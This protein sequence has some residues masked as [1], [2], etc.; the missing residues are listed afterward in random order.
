MEDYDSLYE[1]IKHNKK[2]AF[3]IFCILII[4][5]LSI[6]LYIKCKEKP[7]I[8]YKTKKVITK[9]VKDDSSIY[10]VDIKGK[11][12]KPGVYEV[13]AGTRISDVIEKAGGLLYG[14]NTRYLNMAKKVTD[15]LVIVVYSDSEIEE[16]LEK[17]ELE[18][19]LDIEKDTNLIDNKTSTEDKTKK[20]ININTATKEELMNLTGIGEAKADAII[21]YRNKTKFTKIEDLMNVTGIGESIFEKIKNNI[22]I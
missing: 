20:V 11:I 9:C 8:K 14:A 7:I 22:T 2:T 19:N 16:M 6:S 12:K 3:I 1:Y 13:E 10:I 5:T 4:I 21:E 18:E 15:E 17:G